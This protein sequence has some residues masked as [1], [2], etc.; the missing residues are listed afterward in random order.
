M[1][2]EAISVLVQDLTSKAAQISSDVYVAQLN[3]SK[4]S[5]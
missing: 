2:L 4:S 5:I 1:C 3:I